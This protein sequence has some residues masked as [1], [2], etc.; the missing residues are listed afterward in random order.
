MSFVNIR[1]PD[2][3]AAGAGCELEFN[4]SVVEAASGARYRNSKWAQPLRR[5]TIATFN[6]EADF[7]EVRAF[8]LV[9]GGRRDAFRFRDVSDFQATGEVL[10]A[11]DGSITQF[12]L[13]KTYAVGGHV[14]VRPITKPVQGTVR[15]Y[16]GGTEKL[17]GWS[18]DHSTGVVTFT[19]APS[20]VVTADFEFDVPAAFETDTLNVEVE[21]G[22]LWLTEAI[23][24]VEERE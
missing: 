20:G 22:R 23:K 10:G 6:S 24:I 17:S 11:G 12:S 8:H 2:R 16:V 7:Q 1:F 15:V 21:G 4:T 19:T 14:F 3:V 13:R 18:C 9:L 5:W